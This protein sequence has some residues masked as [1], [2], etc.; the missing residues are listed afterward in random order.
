METLYNIMETVYKEYNK[1]FDTTIPIPRP[2]GIIEENVD[3]MQAA[4]DAGI[5]INLKDADVQAQW[6]GYAGLP[7]DAVL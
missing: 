3:M 5:A 7:P 4:L 1:R 2:G 6:Y